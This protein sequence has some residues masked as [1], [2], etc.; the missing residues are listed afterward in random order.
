MVVLNFIWYCIKC[1]LNLFAAA[2]G[3]TPDGFS[4]K[5]GLIGGA[6]LIVI[7]IIIF[8][9]LWLTGVIKFKKKNKANYQS[10]NDKN[11]DKEPRN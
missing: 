4:L 7:M 1:M 2:F 3:H 11:T 6:T 9:I 8:L 10:N 5:E